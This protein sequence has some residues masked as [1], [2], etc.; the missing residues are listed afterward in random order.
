[1]RRLLNEMIAKSDVP[2]HASGSS[3]SMAVAKE[4]LSMI[5][6][7]RHKIKKFFGVGS[8]VSHQRL[9][10]SYIKLSLDLSNADNVTWSEIEAYANFF[11]L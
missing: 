5:P 3:M 1:M 11:L 6:V 7:F 10:C 9:D 2:V 8:S 4:C